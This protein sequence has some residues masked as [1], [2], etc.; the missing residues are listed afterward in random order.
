MERAVEDLAMA[1]MVAAAQGPPWGVCCHVQQAVEK[2]L[3][4]LLVQE[5]EDPPR[6]HNR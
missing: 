6:T 5:G 2:G 4:A 1:E 3:K